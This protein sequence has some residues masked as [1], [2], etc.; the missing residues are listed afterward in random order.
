MTMLLL[1]V[2]ACASQPD[3][4]PDPRDGAYAGCLLSFE[5]WC[6]CQPSVCA[7]LSGPEQCAGYL[8]IECEP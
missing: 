2:L 6:E 5:A 7:D 3:S 1:L 4:A 8:L